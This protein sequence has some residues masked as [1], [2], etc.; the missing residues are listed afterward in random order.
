MKWLWKLTLGR[1]MVRLEYAFTEVSGN[2]VYYFLDR[3][4]RVWMAKSTWSIFRVS[5]RHDPKVADPLRCQKRNGWS[6]LLNDGIRNAGWDS[7]G[8]S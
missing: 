6:G 8:N 2:E 1:P 7:R 4:G 5:S 3:S